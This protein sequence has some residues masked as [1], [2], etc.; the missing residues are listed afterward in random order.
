MLANKT[1]TITRTILC[2]ACFAVAPFSATAQD[3]NIAPNALIDV[4]QDGSLFITYE[5]Y[6]DRQRRVL[7]SRVTNNVAAPLTIPTR[8]A[9]AQAGVSRPTTTMSLRDQWTIGAFR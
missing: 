5:E 2:V 7:A 6:L 8:R 9:V 4:F 3:Q 1:K